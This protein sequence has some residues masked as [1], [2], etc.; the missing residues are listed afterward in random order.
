MGIRSLGGI[1]VEL[2]QELG[3]LREAIF[4][5]LGGQMADIEIDVREIRLAD[6]L[7][8]RAAYHVSRGQFTCGVIIL[9]EAIAVAIDEIRPFAA[10]GFGDQNPARSG[11][12]Q[13]VW[14][15]TEPSP[16]P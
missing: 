10:D 13:G 4:E 2:G 8:D 3:Q 5:R 9:H 6:L 16:C 15:G 11:D 14:D 12:I 1:D 7:D